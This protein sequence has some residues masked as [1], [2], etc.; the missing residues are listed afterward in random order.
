MTDLSLLQFDRQV[1]QA[2]QQHWQLVSFTGQT[3][4]PCKAQKPALQQVVQ[5]LSNRLQLVE[6]DAEQCQA[7]AAHYQV[8]SLPT[9]LLFDRGELVSRRSGV[10]SAQSLK[11]WLVHHMGE[12]NDLDG[13]AVVSSG[14]TAAQHID[15][16]LQGW[17]RSLTKGQPCERTLQQLAQALIDDGQSARAAQVLQQ[18]DDTLQ[19]SPAIAQIQSQLQLYLQS[20]QP[21]SESDPC[22]SA[23][24]LVAQQQFD[25]ALTLLLQ[26]VAQD[27]Q[28][29]SPARTM[30]VK[31]LNAMPDRQQA[32]HY[33]RQLLAM[34]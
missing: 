27:E 31:V 14:S 2:S 26:A 5:Q 22:N 8:R 24:T 19:R 3:C 30:M 34:G 21:Q 13:D 10:N 28:H 6:L 7:V 1:T 12:S 23:L 29:S 18:A 15:A 9:L 25:A 17:Q 4:A 33:R 32:Q 20:I 11:Q 16:L